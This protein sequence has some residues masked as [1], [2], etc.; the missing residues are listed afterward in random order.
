MPK[1]YTAK[2]KDKTG[3]DI[4]W[5]YEYPENVE[6]QN[7]QLSKDIPKTIEDYKK[8]DFEEEKDIEEIKSIPLG[9]FIAYVTKTK[10]GNKF[11]KGGILIKNDTKYLMLKNLS[12]GRE[13]SVQY[14]NLLA[15]YW[16]PSPKIPL[17]PV[18][19]EP[20]KK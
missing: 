19:E 16:K 2:F 3:K 10:E 8:R 13:R 14:A 17:I 7:E 6:T 20:V 5:T 18:K 1:S 15:I 4:E 11:R 9:S 12:A